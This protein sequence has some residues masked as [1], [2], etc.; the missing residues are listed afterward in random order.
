MEKKEN[1]DD[2]IN[3]PHH[4][5]DYH[6]PMSMRNRAAQFAPF[7]ALSGHDD[8]IEETIRITEVF[9]ELS[10]DEIKLV[11]YKLQYAIKNRSSVSIRYFEPDK[12]KDGGS[13]KSL[14]G[15]IKKWDVIDNILIM[16]EGNKVPVIFISEINIKNCDIEF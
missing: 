8:A 14:S 1:Y 4:V 2:I 5:S 7:A 10:E 6:K 12:K 11:S 13:Y 9:K 16:N 15:S 3:L